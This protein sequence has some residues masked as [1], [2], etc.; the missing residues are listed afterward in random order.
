VFPK[1]T[2]REQEILELI[3]QGMSNPE[4]AKKLSIFFKNYK[5]LDRDV[6]R[7]VW[8]VLDVFRPTF[9]KINPGF[10]D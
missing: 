10:A 6:K 3:A 2:N 1:L 4:I 8:A 9:G 5:P 7:S